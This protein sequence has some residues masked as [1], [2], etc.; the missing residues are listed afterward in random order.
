MDNESAIPLA[1]VE[2]IIFILRGQKVIL[3]TDPA[4]LYGVATKRLN[5]QVNRN[6]NRFPDDFMFQLTPEEKSEV[7]ADCDHLSKLKFSPVFPHALTEHGTI[8][9]ASVL[10]TTRAV[11]ASILVVRAF[12]RL[13]EMQATHKELACKFERLEGRI[14]EHDEQIQA[15]FEAIQQLMAPPEKKRNKIGF[16]VREDEI[17]YGTKTRRR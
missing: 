3:D 13:R 17:K 9:A 16:E 10:N 14:A 1:R 12:I 5:Q 11:E 8:M 6:L 4:K 15:I 2:R 7:A